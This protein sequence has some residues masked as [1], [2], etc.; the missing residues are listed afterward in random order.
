M[1]ALP[2]TILQ[3]LGRS[4]APRKTVEVAEIRKRFAMHGYG[5]QKYGKWLQYFLEN[6]ILID[7]ED[8]ITC[9][10]W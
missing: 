10:W 4:I 6:E 3:E 2:K 1:V 8:G 7:T 5:K 9:I